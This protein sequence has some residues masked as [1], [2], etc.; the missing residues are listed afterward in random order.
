MTMNV[1]LLGFIGVKR[2]DIVWKLYGEMIDDGIVVDVEIVGYLIQVFCID[3]KVNNGYEF[4][5]QVREGGVVFSNVFMNRLIRVFFL[6]G[7]YGKV[8]E[9]LYLM[10]A[11]NRNSDIYIY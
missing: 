5:Y 3:N 1:V 4:F 2:I 6:N 10:I 9:F 8:F 7:S 11:S